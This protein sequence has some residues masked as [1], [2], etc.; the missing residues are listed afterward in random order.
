MFIQNIHYTAEVYPKI[1]AL[2]KFARKLDA[3]NELN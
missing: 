1:S 2:V 3:L